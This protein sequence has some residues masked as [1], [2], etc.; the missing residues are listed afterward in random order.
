LPPQHQQQRHLAQ[1]VL[2]LRCLHSPP[3]HL[4]LLLLLPAAH[5]SCAGCWLLLA[6]LLPLL[7]LLV[8]AA[9][10]KRCHLDP[11]CLLL[12]AHLNTLHPRCFRLHLTEQACHPHHHW[13]CHRQGNPRC[14]FLQAR[15]FLQQLA[16]RFLQ[17]RL[18]PALQCH[19]QQAQRWQRHVLVLPLALVL[20]VLQVLLHGCCLQELPALHLLQTPPAARPRRQS[21]QGDRRRCLYHHLG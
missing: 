2:P 9:W 12:L 16:A 3:L 1:V 10:A 11:C 18:V 20:Q 7:A 14:R 21:S 4:Q 17:A 19:W 13:C 15:R 8:L 5:L 6:L